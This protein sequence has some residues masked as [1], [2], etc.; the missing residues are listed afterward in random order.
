MLLECKM[1]DLEFVLADNDIHDPYLN[2]FTQ[3]AIDAGRELSLFHYG[4]N[5][6]RVLKHKTEDQSIVVWTFLNLET[7]TDGTARK[8]TYEYYEPRRNPVRIYKVSRN[9]FM[10]IQNPLPHWGI[11]T[12]LSITPTAPHYL[13][14]EYMFI[15][16]KP[17]PEGRP[18][19]FLVPNY[20]N[21]PDDPRIHF[22]AGGR[23]QTSIADKSFAYPCSLCQ[24]ELLKKC[25]R[26]S[27]GDLHDN[28]VLDK[29][30]FYGRW[31]SLVLALFFASDED[32][33]FV[34]NPVGG[35]ENNPAWDIQFYLDNPQPYKKYIFPGRMML[36][37]FVSEDDILKEYQNWLEKLT[38]DKKN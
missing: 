10:L 24:K 34:V 21:A 38:H 33:S 26:P 3:R 8:S 18:F 30:F 17:A 27:L 13:D 9:K 35:S 29:P 16:H 15:T 12:W 37:P 32:I 14:L 7:V 36:K 28:I 2:E 25:E 23:W 4:Y 6:L 1:F 20:I 5:G 22:R 11:E 19:L 31:R